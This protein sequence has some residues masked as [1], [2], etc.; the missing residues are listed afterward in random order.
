MGCAYNNTNSMCLGR[1]FTYEE[2]ISLEAYL[3]GHS[4]YVKVTNRSTL[5]SIFH[6]SRRTIQR[7]IQRGL[8]IH[9]RSEIPFEV[10]EY[11]AEYAQ[12]LA[13]SNNSAKGPDLKIGH[14]RIL[15]KAIN[16]Y[17][18]DLKYHMM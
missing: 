14:D 16:H 6:K 1:Y 15:E 12:N 9:Q 10:K 3:L 5:A 7:E 8:V 2:R 18:K 17:V 13:I 11:N 4:H